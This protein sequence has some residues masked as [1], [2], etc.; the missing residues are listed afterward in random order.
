MLVWK[1]LEGIL[2]CLWLKINENKEWWSSLNGISS[3]FELVTNVF[4][5]IQIQSSVCLEYLV[6]YCWICSK[7]NNYYK[8]HIHNTTDDLKSLVREYSEIYL[9][10]KRGQEGKESFT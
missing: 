9:N 8:T 3:P 10:K 6:I 1:D 7:R 4:M 2:E 5:E